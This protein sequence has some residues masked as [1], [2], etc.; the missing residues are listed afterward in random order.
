MKLKDLL[1]APRPKT[2][3][4]PY[5]SPLQLSGHCLTTLRG[6]PKTV[7]DFCDISS[8]HLTS[9]IGSPQDVRGHFNCAYNKLTSLK[10]GPKTVRRDFFCGGNQL[11]SLIGSPETIGGDFSCY[12]NSLTSLDGITPH[13]PYGLYCRENNLTSLKGIHKQIKQIDGIAIFTLNPIKSHVLGLLKISGLTKVEFDNKEVKDILNKHL[14]GDKD[15]F[16]CQE[17]LIEAGFP[18]FAQL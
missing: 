16:A 10:G 3:P 6:L 18:E 13:L 9:L 12:D 5:K 15:I 1:E 4:D 8:N 11:T 14:K 2:L 17:E 7:L